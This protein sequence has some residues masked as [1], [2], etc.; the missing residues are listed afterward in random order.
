MNDTEALRALECPVDF[1]ADDG[2]LGLPRGL[3]IALMQ[4]YIGV[5]LNSGKRNWKQGSP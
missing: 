2:Q 4:F 1:R 5:Q 3:A